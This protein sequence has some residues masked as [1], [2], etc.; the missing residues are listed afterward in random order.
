MSAFRLVILFFLL[1]LSGCSS[2]Y[3]RSR[4][5]QSYVVSGKFLEAEKLLDSDKKGETGINRVLY[6]FNRGV[7][8]FM[9]REYEKSNYYFTKADHYTED[10]R[11]SVGWEA[12]SLI[13]NP[14]I[15]PYRP[16]DF[17][18]VMIHYYMA[19]NYIY[20]NNYEDALVE[21]RRINIQLQRLNSRY[22][23]GKNKY[24]K[25][26]FANV[27]MGLIYEASGDL[28]NAFVAYRNALEIYQ[29]EY[30]KLFGMKAPLQL[31]K[32]ILR[33]ASA[34][35]FKNE[36]DF[37]QKKFGMKPEK[38]DPEKG[39][40]VFFWMNGFGPVKGQW[41]LTFINSG[42]R[43][44]WVTF[45]NVEYGL[46]FPVYVG[47]KSKD[48]RQAFAN[49]SV[50]RVAFPKYIERKRLYF[51]AQ[52]I[53]DGNLYHLEM[54]ENINAIAFQ[55]L[56]DRM[57]REIALGIARLAT[58]KALEE[59]ARK[60]NED[61]GAII[62]I[63]NAMTENADTRNWQTLPYSISYARIPM[64]EGIHQVRLKAEGNNLS[65]TTDFE[66]TIH[67]GKTTFFA[68]HQLQS[69]GISY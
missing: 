5:L 10:Y 16:E 63:I 34:L 67:K 25:D 31:K 36:L 44:G 20:M 58:K 42:Y 4:E 8:A 14:M 48:E 39:Y 51:N 28:N 59:L 68:F 49:L 50:L 27:L 56:K 17:E 57:V 64:S 60:K 66:F 3:E 9:N 21:C 12:L 37:Y 53:Y 69:R 19:L 11:R 38:P 47:D 1:S 24:A 43:N 18:A 13:S 26:A 2:Y 55:C 29:T 54:A 23:N 45:T 30:A 15:K 33:T 52:L 61:F 65:S 35:G 7:V 22:K 46:S 62:G 32:D 6:F 40:L 41:S